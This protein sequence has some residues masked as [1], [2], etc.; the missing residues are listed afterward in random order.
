MD[1]FY[2]H[3]KIFGST[4]YRRIYIRV[5]QSTNANFA[6]RK[7]KKRRFHSVRILPKN[8][9]LT[10]WKLTLKTFLHQMMR[11]TIQITFLNQINK[12]KSKEE[13]FIYFLWLY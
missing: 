2:V 8:F 3:R 12:E 5:K 1:N 4:Y 6:K 10:C 9:V 13:T 7:K 11:T